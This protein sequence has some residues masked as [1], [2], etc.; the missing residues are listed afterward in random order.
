VTRFLQQY[1]PLFFSLFFAL[2]FGANDSNAASPLQKQTTNSAQNNK[3]A[4]QLT[5]H[6]WNGKRLKVT[7]KGDGKGCVYKSPWRWTF[8]N[9][10]DWIFNRDEAFT[11]GLRLDFFNMGNMSDWALNLTEMMFKGVLNKN[12]WFVAGFGFFVQQSMYTPVDLTVSTLQKDDRPY[13]GWLHAGAYYQLGTA[14]WEL[15]LEISAGIIGEFSGAGQL[16]YKWHEVLIKG[17]QKDTP[18][19]LGWKHQLPTE[20]A[21]QL[22]AKWK[23]FLGRW[24]WN[25]VRIADIAMSG[26]V[27]LGN[28]FI[29]MTPEVIARIGY[30]GWRPILS[31]TPNSSWLINANL[32][33][34]R[35]VIGKL[36][37]LKQDLSTLQTHRENLEKSEGFTGKSKE[38]WEAD[39]KALDDKEKRLLGTL[40]RLK[41]KHK[42][43][44][45]PAK[46]AR[47]IESFQA[48]LYARGASRLTLH[49]LF[50]GGSFFTNSH[51]V[52][53]N[54]MVFEVE[55]GGV[56]Q[57]PIAC[58]ALRLSLGAV[59]RTPEGFY[60]KAPDPGHQIYR[61]SLS[62][63]GL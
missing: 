31:D 46:K 48:Y 27:E 16:Q 12:D 43:L 55:M 41:K 24:N 36:S 34:A 60:P 61:F 23:S 39:K 15:T 33:E 59:L 28:V 38:K 53:N 18:L 9:D 49:N 6:R 32:S 58:F 30:L 25:K 17:G 62:V 22:R 1:S 57:I 40:D 8:L 19:P 42:E 45:A 10:N 44:T 56:V 3:P 47:P 7:P 20:F 35:I 51:R 4:Q 29:R 63:L 50:V 37:K 13:G 54:P 52:Q 5:C 14:D 21:F 26:E 2:I 11:N